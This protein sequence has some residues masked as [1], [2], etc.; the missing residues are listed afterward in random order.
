MEAS[1]VDKGSG[2][3]TRTESS[4]NVDVFVGLPKG[5]TTAG[6]AL[7]FSERAVVELVMLGFSN[8]AI[9]S[10]RGV[11]ARTIAHQ[12]TNAYKKLG[13]GSRRELL[14]VAAAPT[15]ALDATPAGLLSFREQQVLARANLGC[16]NKVIAYALSLSI[17]T[18]STVLTR[19]RRKLARTGLGAQFVASA[20]ALHAGRPP[21]S[22]H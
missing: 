3:G 5:P 7:S 2:F 13:V 10:V 12:L 8:H 14:A 16:A 4:P 20:G 1:M 17:S 15:R 22:R 9:A 6:V 19:A 21:A 18:V 11:S